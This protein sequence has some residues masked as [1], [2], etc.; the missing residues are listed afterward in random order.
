[1]LLHDKVVAAVTRHQGERLLWVA[2]SRSPWCATVALLAQLPRRFGVAAAGS[3]AVGR[4]A[5]DE[6]H[7]LVAA[8]TGQE[9]PDRLQ[10]A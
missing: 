1:M 6:W 3:P 8:V 7:V 5:D 10:S 4:L 9:T 2:K